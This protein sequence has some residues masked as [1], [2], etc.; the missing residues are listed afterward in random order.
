M[1]SK[2]DDPKSNL[3]RAYVRLLVDQ[4]TVGKNQI[5]IKGSKAELFRAVTFQG[6]SGSGQ[7]PSSIPE[8]RANQR[9]T[10]E[11]I[12]ACDTIFDP[13]ESESG[14]TAE[15]ALHR[16]VLEEAGYT[17]TNLRLIHRFYAAPGTLLEH[18]SLFAADAVV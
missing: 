11:P 7:V 16:E 18:V 3:R 12:T 13:F 17:I 8:W 14:E 10:Y 9:R 4:V 5:E 2:L 15:Q 6:G 1:R